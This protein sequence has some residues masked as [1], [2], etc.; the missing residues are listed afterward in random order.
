MNGDGMDRRGRRRDPGFTLIEL[1]VVIA[2]IGI[3]VSIAAPTGKPL[4]GTYA[5]AAA[6][7]A[8][9]SSSSSLGG[10]PAGPDGP[11]RLLGPVG[12]GEGAVG[13]AVDLVVMSSLMRSRLAPS[14]D[15]IHRPAR[16]RILSGVGV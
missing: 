9:S 15:K 7:R 8:R 1:M 14:T 10:S 4:Y 3:L 11:P 16:T 5:R 12:G 2:I 13:P 6:A